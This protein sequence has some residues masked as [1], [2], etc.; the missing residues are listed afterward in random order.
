MKHEVK[1]PKKLRIAGFSYTISM[2]PKSDR[3]LESNSY[4]GTHS[5]HLRTINIKS[6]LTP[7]EM[8]CTLLHEYMHAVELL[9]CAGRLSEADIG[10]LSNGLHQILEELGVRFVK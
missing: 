4:R 3:Q 2:N 9:Y 5:D 1:I 8:S 7:Q 10:G 6:D